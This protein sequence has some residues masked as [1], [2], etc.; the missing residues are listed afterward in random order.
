MLIKLTDIKGRD[1]WIN[2]AYV[3]GV[4]QKSKEVAE[5]YVRWGSGLSVSDVLKVRARADDVAAGISAAM[6]DA[7]AYMAVMDSEEEYRRQQEQA[8]RASGMGG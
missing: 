8:T 1:I 7:A 3:K 6:P 2:P 4:F 5:V